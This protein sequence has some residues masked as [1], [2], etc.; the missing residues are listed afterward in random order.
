M[1]LINIINYYGIVV[2][3]KGIYSIVKLEQRCSH[4]VQLFYELGLV[5]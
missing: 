2:L 1:K 5:C 4:V 3:E